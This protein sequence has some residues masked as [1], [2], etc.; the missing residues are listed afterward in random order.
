MQSKKMKSTKNLIAKDTPLNSKEIIDFANRIEYITK[1]LEVI[2][3]KIEHDDFVLLET[4]TFIFKLPWMS[5]E[6][7]KTIEK[8]YTLD[9]R[10]VFT[11]QDVHPDESYSVSKR[12]PVL[13][14][15]VRKVY[16]SAMDKCQSRKK[17]GGKDE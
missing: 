9:F 2:Q 17:R 5:I 8:E 11:P 6:F 10:S 7:K 16:Q 4:S 3:Y 15:K 14:M 1:I 13:Y 12:N